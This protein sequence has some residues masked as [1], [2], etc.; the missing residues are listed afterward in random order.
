MVDVES[1]LFHQVESFVLCFLIYCFLETIFLRLWSFFALEEYSQ[2]F[3]LY[4]VHPYCFK[5]YF[6]HRVDD[7]ERNN[8]HLDAIL[9]DEAGG[10]V[11]DQ[12]ICY[13]KSTSSVYEV[14][15]N[16]FLQMRLEVVC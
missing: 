14:R 13:Y 1:V 11:G 12:Q 5:H 3:L 16:N 2:H 7:D 4:L 8:L 10:S 15:C 9:H 6:L